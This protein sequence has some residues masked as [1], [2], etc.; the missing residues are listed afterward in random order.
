M[1]EIR[2]EGK[3]IKDAIENGL[4]QINLTREQVDVEVVREEKKGL[5]GIG[6]HNACVVLREKIWGDESKKEKKAEEK[7]IKLELSSFGF[8]PTGN[9]LEN[10]K[11]LLTDI[12]TFSK[13][14]FRII[15][16]SYNEAE[17]TVYIN[18]E[19]RDAGLLL[20]DGARGLLSLQQF[21]SIV[22]NRDDNNK[23]I[24]FRLDTEDFWAKTEN[25]IKRDIEH[26][27]E[28]IKRTK[29]SYGMKPMHSSF[30]KIIHDMVKN[31][32]PDYSTFSTGHGKFRKV[33]IKPNFRRL[34]KAK[35][36]LVDRKEEL[37]EEK[38][39]S[40]KENV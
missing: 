27:I 6:A 34:G 9:I 20:Y 26:A 31:D 32:Y 13:I 2:A 33:I 10:T 15:S 37:K 21:I 1:K 38:V 36:S 35:Q 40:K 22:L 39:E 12:L 11:K 16:S 24:V 3:T 28:V 8:K 17:K 23:K 29:K 14:D 7:Q 19:T 30:R 25:R 5:F 18:I 4:K